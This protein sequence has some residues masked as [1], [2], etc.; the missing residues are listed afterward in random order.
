M[1]TR[2]FITVLFC[3]FWIA[4]NQEPCEAQSPIASPKASELKPK[5]LQDWNTPTPVITLKKAVKKTA[6]KTTKK[7]ASIKNASTTP[8]ILTKVQWKQRLTP[9][10]F[11]ILRQKGTERAF[12]GEYVY[13]KKKGL[14]RCAACNAPLF[15]SKTKFRSGTGWPSFHTALPNR[16]KRVADRSHGKVRTEIVCS[17]C[18]S[19]LGHVF[20]DG[21]KPTG[22]RHCVNSIS[23]KFEAQ[24]AP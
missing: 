2:L 10:E 16:V 1:P 13:N 18:N 3:I 7:T 8:V 20:K 19:H 12:S 4:C 14:Y 22:E 23:L 11:Y 9:K 5:V 21:P 17:R 6:K 24:K 15:L